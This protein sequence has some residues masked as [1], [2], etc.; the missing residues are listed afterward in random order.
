[1]RLQ[2]LVRGFEVLGYVWDG[3]VTRT[4]DLSEAQTDLYRTPRQPPLFHRDMKT[5]HHQPVLV[6][7]RPERRRRAKKPR[8]SAS[9]E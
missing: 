2:R 7:R 9:E 6:L 4:S 3:K 5:E 1:M 8:V